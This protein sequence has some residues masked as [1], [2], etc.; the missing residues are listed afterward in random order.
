MAA[1][2]G[3]W[4]TTADLAGMLSVSEA[5]VRRRAASGQWPHQRIGRL[6]RFTDDDIQEI[7]AKLTAEI[8]YFYDRDRVAQLLRRK[9][10]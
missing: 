10:A 8:D 9:I 6:Y 7:K 2:S 3:R 5:T 1:I 4:W